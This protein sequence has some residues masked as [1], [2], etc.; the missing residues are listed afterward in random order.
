MTELKNGTLQEVDVRQHASMLHTYLGCLV[1]DSELAEDIAQETF[2][3]AFENL[4][5]LRS[6]QAFP[7]WLR[8][9]ARN[10][11][12]DRIREAKR[13]IPTD[14]DV[15][16]GMEDIFSIFDDSNRGDTWSGKL[17]LVRECLR[18][19]SEAM[20]EVIRMFYWENLS[21][22]AIAGKLS[23]SMATVYKRLERGKA[24]VRHCVE[25]NAGLEEID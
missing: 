9:I 1:G 12:I 10:V 5:S 4:E 16:E 6:D 25:K 3:R 17:D 22:S 2:V 11:T 7:A 8:A 13:E 23:L 24:E 21:P 15:I 18:H 19:L 14:P 20:R